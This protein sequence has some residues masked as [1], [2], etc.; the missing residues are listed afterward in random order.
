MLLETVYHELHG[1]ARRYLGQERAG[2][3]V[4][5]TEIVSEAYLRLFRPGGEAGGETWASR[6]SFYSVASQA[7]RR[8]LIDHAR[9][10]AAVV[11]GG[12]DGS[13][14]RRRVPMPLDLLRAAEDADPA[15]LVALSTLI[16]RLEEVD[17]RAAEVVRLRFYAGLTVEQAAE[18]LE[19]SVRTVKRDWELARAWL[20]VRI[21]EQAEDRA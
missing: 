14:G 21:E 1:I 20:Q 7:M 5:A 2:I 19:L 12:G 6:R 4:G 11:R 16:V 8:V 15:E 17:A 18:V 13:T 3:T 9:K 10:R